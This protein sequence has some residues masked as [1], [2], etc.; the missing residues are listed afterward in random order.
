MEA[1]SSELRCSHR[2]ILCIYVPTAIVL[3]AFAL[4]S[5]PLTQHRFHPD[6]AWYAHFARLVASGRDPWLSSVT[7]D[8]PPIP[9]Y[10]S[11]ASLM[12]MAPIPSVPPLVAEMATRLPSL[13]AGTVSMALIYGLA[14]NMYGRETGL[15]AATVFTL[16]PLS[17]LF[18]T[19]IFADTL[20]T[21]F[22][23]W[24]LWAAIRRS[25][26]WSGIAF[27]LALCCKQ[28]ALF[29][30]PLVL[31]LGLLSTA[32][33]KLN[34]IAT[35]RTLC[36]WISPILIAAIV[37]YIWDTARD[38]DISFWMQGYRD[39][40]PQRFIR[41]NE[42]TARLREI[43]RLTHYFTAS[44]IVNAL[45]L[46]GST[47]LVT[48]ACLRRA[49]KKQDAYDL[50]MF[51]FCVAYLSTYWL[52]AFNL[53][54]RYI[55]AIVPVFCLM[56]ARIAVRAANLRNPPNITIM[57]NKASPM[58]AAILLVVLL[59]PGLKAASSRYPIGGDHGAYDGIAKVAAAIHN[60]PEGSVI[61]DHW[62][63]WQWSF[64]LF[65]SPTYLAWVPGPDALAEDLAAH[66]SHG[67][68]YFVA[69]AWESFSELRT[70]INSVGFQAIPVLTTYR[71]NGTESFTLYKLTNG[72]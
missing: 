53:W 36:L 5:V 49:P 1:N 4:R 26:T 52:L 67:Q 10:L 45:A 40:N 27:A 22:L 20:L 56:L 37:L 70:A 72:Q 35:I 34:S 21:T 38:S 12:L 23:I 62:L 60:L 11:A 59:F 63:S 13:A 69:P 19:T 71:G 61:Y 3:L 48:S 31:S 47:V 58:P 6:E 15:A 44:S 8:K 46:A 68:R 25:W 9:F 17:I 65:D 43:A 28:T 14:S 54:D 51:G 24:S 55:L 29:F 50:L 7:V 64:Y 57:G 39:N 32:P 66:G 42:I 16:S 30:A 41:S 18:S 2:I 33:R